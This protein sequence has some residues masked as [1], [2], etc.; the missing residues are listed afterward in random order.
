MRQKEDV[1]LEQT[2]DLTYSDV[3]KDS[4]DGE[5]TVSMGEVSNITQDDNENDKEDDDDLTS[6]F[7]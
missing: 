2:V 6:Y 1:T 4:I 5:E 7:N 3:D